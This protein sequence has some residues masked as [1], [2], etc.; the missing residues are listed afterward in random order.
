ML[1]RSLNLCVSLKDPLYDISVFLRL[2]AWIGSNSV[3]VLS[4]FHRS[5]SRQRYPPH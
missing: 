1:Q 2:L 3:M 5:E 4:S